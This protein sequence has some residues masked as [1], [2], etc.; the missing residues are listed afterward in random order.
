MNNTECMYT[1]HLSFQILIIAQFS[2]CAVVNPTQEN[3]K[4]F[5]KEHPR[6]YFRETTQLQWI[7]E[8][9]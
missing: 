8:D 4:G 2:G 5:K 3:W 6:Q 9:K 7:I 1:N